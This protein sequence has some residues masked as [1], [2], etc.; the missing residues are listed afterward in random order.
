MFSGQGVLCVLLTIVIRHPV[1]AW[2]P[3]LIKNANVPRRVFDVAQCQG[4]LRRAHVILSVGWGDE[5]EGRG[6]HPAESP[7]SHNQS[8]QGRATPAVGM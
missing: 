7:E 6:G 4:R 8:C 3:L 1:S 5:E 2:G